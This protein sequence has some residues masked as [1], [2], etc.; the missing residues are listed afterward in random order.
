MHTVRI[1]ILF[2]FTPCLESLQNIDNR[3]PMRYYSDSRVPSDLL[4]DLVGA[5]MFHF[6]KEKSWNERIN[7]ENKLHVHLELVVKW[8]LRREY[9]RSAVCATREQRN[10]CSHPEIYCDVD[11]KC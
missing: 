11:L 3:T 4:S 5:M 8:E 10:L 2:L 9:S 7:V 6:P 1:V